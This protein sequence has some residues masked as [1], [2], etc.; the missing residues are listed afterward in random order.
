MSIVSDGRGGKAVRTVLKANT[1]HSIP[2]GDNG[3]N[4]FIKLPA[5]YDTACMSYD[6]KF[7]AN[8]D[9]SLGGKL[10]GLEGVASGVAPATPTGGNHTDLGWSGRG[11]WV[12]PKA[13]RWAGTTNMAVSYMYHPG[14]TGTYGDDV[15]W[16]KSYVAGTWHTVKQCHTMNTIGKADGV[17]QAWFDGTQVLDDH[18]YTYRTNSTVHINYI[19]FALFRGGNTIDWAGKID[20][21]VDITNIKVSSN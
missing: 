12:G 3:D 20:N 16:N 1:I 11:M 21:T 2:A 4:L 17:L 18:A 10:P 5:D 13:Y 6:I 19:A 8:F 14:Q 15:R 7:D 9:W